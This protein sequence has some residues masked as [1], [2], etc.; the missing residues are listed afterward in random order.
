MV[1]NVFIIKHSLQD[2]PTAVLFQSQPECSRQ[3]G[4][5]ELK[6]IFLAQILNKGYP[7][8][9]WQVYANPVEADFHPVL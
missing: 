5:R 8:G 6:H 2:L 3:Q 9:G 7:V 4:I 1:D